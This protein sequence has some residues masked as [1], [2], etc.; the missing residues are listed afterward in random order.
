MQCHVL[1]AGDVDQHTAGTVDACVFEQRGGNRTLRSFGGPVFAFGNTGSHQ[2]HAHTGHHRSHVGKI[3]VDFARDGDQVGNT[4]HRLTQDVIRHVERL[5]DRCA[6]IDRVQQ[7]VVGDC[8]DRVDHL[9]EIFETFVRLRTASAT[10]ECEGLRDD[11][12]DKRTHLTGKVGNDRCCTCSRAPAE[13]GRDKHHVGTAENF[14]DLFCVFECRGTAD[15][16]IAA[17]T[18]PACQFGTELQLE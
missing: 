12:H 14:D 5:C 9:L 10:F 3:E 17:G 4:L 1:A 13:P 2:R 16:G 8:D 11:G 7:L 15:F 6:R 18:Q